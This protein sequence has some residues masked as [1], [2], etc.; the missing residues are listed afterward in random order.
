MLEN[1]KSLYGYKLAAL[2]GDI[3]RVQDFYFDDKA[4]VVRYLVADTGS[5]LSGRQVLLTPHTFGDLD[6]E[7]RA[8]SVNLTRKRIENSPTIELH[9]P[10]SRQ[11]EIDYYQYYGWPAYWNTAAWAGFGDCPVVVAPSEDQ[12]EAQRSHPH[13]EDKHLRSTRAVTG[14]AIHAADG[15]IG[16]VRGFIV[17][18]K[19]WTIRDLVAEAG[20][21]YSGKE[22]L[23]ASAKIG[24]ISYEDSRV[25]V[26]LTRSAIQHT[27]AHKVVKA[28][29]HDARASAAQNQPI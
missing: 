26:N 9:R 29:A 1:I 11:Y 21:W 23:I 16:S 27:A 18:D 6:R 10:V 17:D 13:R 14:Y 20:H 12:I 2:D 25:F 4:W 8:L 7:G 28:G 5:W 15:E 3:G 22:V 24:R 19:T